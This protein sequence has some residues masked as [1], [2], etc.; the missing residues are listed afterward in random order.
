M[1]PE[2]AKL[3]YDMKQA[4]AR[5]RRF[6]TGRSLADYT[7]DD[8]LRSADERQFDIIGEA[9]T[10]LMKRDQALAE[11]FTDFRK[12][13]GFRNQLIHGYDSI[14]DETTWSIIKMKLPVLQRELN[15]LLK[16]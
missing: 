12:I 1:P 16:D 14:D 10:R 7:N 5:I 9:M 8:F 13:A 11:T 6:A 15:H 4:A 2:T 3:L